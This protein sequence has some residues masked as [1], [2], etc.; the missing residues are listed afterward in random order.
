MKCI[1]VVSPPR[2][3][4][5]R[6]VLSSLFTSL[7]SFSFSLQRRALTPQSPQTTNRIPCHQPSIH[8][9]F[10]VPAV[11]AAICLLST[12]DWIYVVPSI[13]R[14]HLRHASFAD[15]L[16][17]GGHGFLSPTINCSSNSSDSSVPLD[18]LGRFLS[19]K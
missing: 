7:F 8:P 11:C 13:P 9:R 2:A 6:D 16:G 1:F 12:L 14:L 17:A 5:A 18:S 15:A 19:C 4:R 3:S 10:P